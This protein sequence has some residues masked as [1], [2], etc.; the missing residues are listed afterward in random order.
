[1][2]EFLELEETVGR[3]WHRLVGDTSS[4]PRHPNHAVRLTEIKPQLAVCFRAFGGEGT[5]Q[6]QNSRPK[7]SLHRLRLRQVVGLG[8]ERCDHA[9]W[10][11]SAV[12]LPAVV[13]M[14]DHTDLNRDLYFWLAAYIATAPTYVDMPQDAALA[15]IARIELGRATAACVIEAFPGMQERYV[16]LSLAVLACRRRGKLPFVESE[17]ERFVQTALSS[18]FDQPLADR[19]RPAFKGAPAGYLPMLP[20]PIWPDFKHLSNGGASN[21]E[22]LPSEGDGPQTAS[23]PSQEAR[24]T[25]DAD[26][27]KRDPFIL[28]RFEKILAMAEMVNVDRPTDDREDEDA[29]A[30]DELDEITLSETRERPKSKFHFDLDLSPEAVDPTRITGEFTYSEWNYR[31]R[32]Y[33]EDHCRVVAGPAVEAD[34]RIISSDQTVVRKVRRQ[35]ET[36]RPKKRNPTSAVGRR[37][38]GR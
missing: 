21:R 32:A 7:T 1:M 9:Y 29:R 37:R 16:R 38:A 18:P 23:R 25:K 20:V 17:V 14:F 11:V 33:L 35:F 31:K 15:D 12:H 13:D 36:L 19:V 3:A 34:D 10:D 4:W 24:R 2:L 30:S 8:E 5:L 26:D 27:R 6:I 28:N 22:D